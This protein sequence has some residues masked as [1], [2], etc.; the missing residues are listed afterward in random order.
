MQG[1][2]FAIYPDGEHV[3]LDL[4]QRTIRSVTYV[5]RDVDYAMTREKSTRRWVIERLQSSTPT[6]TVR[7]LL[8]QPEITDTIFSGIES[9]NSGN[10]EPPKHFTEDALGHLKRMNSLFTGRDRLSHLEFSLN[11][12]ALTVLR[13][14]IGEKVNRILRGGYWNLSSLEGTLEALN[15]HGNPT[16]TIWDRVSKSPV[17]C[18][19][20]KDKEW[21]ERVKTLLENRVLVRGKVNYFR[22]GVPRFISEIEEMENRSPIANLPKAAFGSIPS[23]EA[24]KDVVGFLRRVR[25]GG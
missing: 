20:P 7:P 16:F 6:L 2:T 17:R 3:S 18:Y 14:D 13:D 19:F 15:F 23:D 1:L 9:I 8:E 22:N 5:V 21:K 11:G 24:A 12:S 25:Q 10:V 4:F